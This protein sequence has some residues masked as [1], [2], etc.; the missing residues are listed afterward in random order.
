MS[1]L[2]RPYMVARKNNG[3]KWEPDTNT[4][5]WLPGQDD[6]YSSTIR[7]RSG[8]GNDG[9]ITGSMW[10][11][12]GQGIWGLSSPGETSANV[13]FSSDLM[14]AAGTVE[15]WINWLSSALAEGHLSHLIGDMIYQHEAN[16][17]IYLNGGGMH[18]V[19]VPPTTGEFHNW[20][21]TWTDKTDSATCNLYIDDAVQTRANVSSYALDSIERFLNLTTPDPTRSLKVEMYLARISNAVVDSHFAEERHL[22][23]V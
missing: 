9:T 6:A 18:F 16:D 14:T 2:T 17:Q 3:V 7:D 13:A 23:N 11:Q 5:L 21:F 12:N 19:Y 15:F 4:V 8:N 10:K 20:R 1:I 22:F